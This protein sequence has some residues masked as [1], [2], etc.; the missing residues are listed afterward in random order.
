MKSS[1]AMYVGVPAYCIDPFPRSA[2]IETL[3]ISTKT[4]IKFGQT[5]ITNLHC[6][7]AIY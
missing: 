3:N 2:Y 4:Y 6:E 7:W 1:G 5:K